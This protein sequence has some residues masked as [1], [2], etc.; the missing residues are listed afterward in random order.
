MHSDIYT[1]LSHQLTLTEGNTILEL[2][3]NPDKNERMVVLIIINDQWIFV[4]LKVR[5]WN[6]IFVLCKNPKQ[7]LRTH[8]DHSVNT[9]KD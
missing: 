6:N 1:A 2:E 3:S 4:Q 7:S 9:F 8:T 5:S